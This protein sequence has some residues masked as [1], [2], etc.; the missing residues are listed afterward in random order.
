MTMAA[1][2]LRPLASLITLASQPIS[3]V[4]Y[5]YPLASTLHAARIHAAYRGRSEAMGFGRRGAKAKSWG[6]EIA[7][8]LIMVGRDGRA[9]RQP[10]R[11]ERPVVLGRS[12]LHLV[13]A[14][15]T[16][17]AASLDSPMD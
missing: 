15:S 1:P 10:L 14:I 17:A 16:P 12:V 4:F 13:S 9:Q 11:Q 2:A 5:P 7:G 8:Y 6:V 3:S